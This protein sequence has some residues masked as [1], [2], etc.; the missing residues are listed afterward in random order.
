MEAVQRRAPDVVDSNEEKSEEVEVEEAAGED[1]TEGCLLREVSRIG[2]RA[3]ID[4][5]MYEGNLDAE[6]ILDWIRSMDR[7]FYYEDINEEKKVKQA[8]TRLKG[9]ATLWWDELQAERRSKGKQ[10]IKSWDRMVAKLKAKFIPKYYQINLF[11]KMKNL[12]QKGMT[13]K[14]YT[15]EFYQLNIIIGK[16]ERDEDKVARY[17]NGLRYEIQDELSMMSVK[18]MEDSYQFVLKAKEKLAR[19]QNQRRRGKNSVP[20]KSQGFNRDRAH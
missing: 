4:V 10:R 5:P 2:G 15:E 1:A 3:K 20:S 8:V 6:E 13:V 12:R 9:H 16:W 7:H 14:E 11:R 19:K 17:I 18:T